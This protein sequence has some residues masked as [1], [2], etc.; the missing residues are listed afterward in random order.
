MLTCGS[1]LGDKFDFKLMESLCVVK[2]IVIFNVRSETEAENLAI[3]ILT[4]KGE[5]PFVKK[6]A[7]ASLRQAS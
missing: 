6:T 7:S 4:E 5:S 3:F 2:V 1:G